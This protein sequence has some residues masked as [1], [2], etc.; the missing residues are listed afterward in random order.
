VFTSRV[1]TQLD[2]NVRRRFVRSS[3]R[4]A[5]SPS[6]GHLLSFVSLLSDDG[7]PIEQISRLVGPSSTSTT[8]LVYRHQIRPM[9]D[10]GA[11]AMNEIFPAV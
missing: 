6:T 8:E 9:V 4:Q 1:G 3:R 5:C 7:M 10:H 11:T 2:A